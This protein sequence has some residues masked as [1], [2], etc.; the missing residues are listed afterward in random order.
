HNIK[1]PDGFSL[2]TFSNFPNREVSKGTIV[3]DTTKLSKVDIITTTQNSLKILET[4]PVLREMGRNTTTITSVM[5]ITVKPISFAPSID[6][7]TLF[8]TITMCLYI[9]TITTMASSTR[10][11]TTNERP[12]SDIRFKVNPNNN[13]PINVEIRQTG[14]AIMTMIAFLKLCKN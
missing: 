1:R 14:I 5:D 7:R 3:N 13:I 12:S 11:P 4:I 2:V 10:I 6:A 9:F 8:L